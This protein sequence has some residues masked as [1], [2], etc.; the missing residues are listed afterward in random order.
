M[1]SELTKEE[2]FTVIQMLQVGETKI[3]LDDIHREQVTS[4]IFKLQH[5]LKHLEDKEDT[6]MKIKQQLINDYSHDFRHMSM[7][8]PDLAEMLTNFAE[9]L[10]EIQ[11]DTTSMEEKLEQLEDY[12]P[13]GDYNPV[14]EFQKVIDSVKK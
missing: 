1:S 13:M 9:E 2:I 11:E 3:N 5:K 10:D 8:Q 4:S 7:K 14:A 12:N 6:K